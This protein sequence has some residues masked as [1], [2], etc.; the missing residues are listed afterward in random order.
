MIFGTICDIKGS[1]IPNSVMCVHVDAGASSGNFNILVLAVPYY[2][3]L[4]VFSEY[5]FKRRG[6][7]SNTTYDTTYVRGC[8]QLLPLV[9]ACDSRL[10]RVVNHIY[11]GKSYSD[12]FYMRG[13]TFRGL[14]FLSKDLMA[15]V[16]VFACTEQRLCGSFWRG[17][18]KEIQVYSL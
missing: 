6:E 5:N 13:C 8:S 11:N 4:G 10:L 17:G 18:K 7:R 16:K 15:D 12:S 1:Y 9:N 2:V 14:H 3:I